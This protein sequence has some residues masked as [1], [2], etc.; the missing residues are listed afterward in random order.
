MIY[1]ELRRTD[2][3]QISHEMQLNFGQELSLKGW[4]P[5]HFEEIFERSFG[6]PAGW[7]L[8][9]LRAVRRPPVHLFVAEEGGKVVGTTF[10]FLQR[11]HG[12]IGAVMTDP[13]FRGKGIAS[14]LLS[15]AERACARR[16][17]RWAV[18]DVLT[19]N[20]VARQLY[21]KRGYRPLRV[22]HWL[23]KPLAQ[24]REAFR[25]AGPEIRAM[26][27][28]D[29]DQL[30]DLYSAQ[31]PPEVREILAPERG[32]L[33][34]PRYLQSL[35]SATSA[36]WCTGALGNPSGYARATFTTPREA[37]NLG[38][39]L[40]AD[41]ASAVEKEELLETALGWL[42]ASGASSVVCEVPAYQ[43]AVLQM[44]QDTGF[45][46]RWTMDTLALEVNGR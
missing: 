39:P 22:Q 12:Y 9:I 11:T 41:R 18:L 35:M 21:V 28:A 36:A 34:P 4:D 5:A 44:L 13:G 40:F 8:A 14:E 25:T 30:L 37:G 38:A 7:V 43:R 10:L 1:R 42:A 26:E 27:K 33:S 45:E 46:E 24:R 20:H 2:V 19:D 3:Q 32:L 29:L 16:G 23:S 17:R 6:F 15:R 31:Q